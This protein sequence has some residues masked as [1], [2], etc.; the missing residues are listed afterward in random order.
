MQHPH[1]ALVGGR[2]F[3]SPTAPSPCV[4]N[5]RVTP[6]A[7]RTH[8]TPKMLHLAPP[9]NAAPEIVFAKP[10]V[11]LIDISR[12]LFLFWMVVVHSLQLTGMRSESMLAYL[13]PPPDIWLSDRFVLLSGMTLALSASAALD[14]GFAGFIRRFWTRAFQIAAIAYLTNVLALVARDIVQLTFTAHSLVAALTLQRE[15]T[16]SSTL[17]PIVL[18]LLAV[19]AM[20]QCAR[21]VPPGAILAVV[22]FAGLLVA[23]PGNR[24]IQALNESAISSALHLSLGRVVLVA[25]LG[26]WT[27]AF[28]MA[29]RHLH[30]LR[31]ATWLSVVGVGALLASY[32]V[33]LP[34]FALYLAKFGSF[35]GA[36]VL[37]IV[38]PV[39]EWLRARLMMLGQNGL[40][41]F[42]GYRILLQSQLLLWP[43]LVDLEY[44]ALL[45]IAITL[46]ALIVLC[47]IRQRRPAFSAALKRIGL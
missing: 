18:L 35:L 33:S 7:A 27:L 47:S 12:G 2:D 26:A 17:L 31:T 34:S 8:V 11:E 37:L 21:R 6:P 19:P 38:M 15:W 28:G 22:T 3:H 40:L 46:A 44:A 4:P 5:E 23:D 10:R 14:A 25:V 24:F 43:A 45:T 42:V 39:P 41:V 16:I 9:V 29:T 13:I 30:P 36:G 20:F 32:V 1:I